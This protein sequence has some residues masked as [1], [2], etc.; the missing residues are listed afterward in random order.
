MVLLLVALV[1]VILQR[2]G[3]PGLGSGE[4]WVPV[5]L[6]LVVQEILGFVDRRECA[7]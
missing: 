2:W 6:V 4:L 1:M 7:L 3:G 5:V